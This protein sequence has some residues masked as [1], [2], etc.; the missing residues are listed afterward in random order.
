MRVL[1]ASRR[2][3][4]SSLLAIALLSGLLVAGIASPWAG[5]TAGANGSVHFSAPGLGGAAL[6][7][8]GAIV[9]GN[10][11]APD[12]G[13]FGGFA[14][15]GPAPA[16]RSFPSFAFDPIDGYSLLFG[17][18]SGGQ[19]LGDTW[20][21]SR[22]NW[23]NLTSTLATGPSPRYGASLA[24]DAVDGYMVLFGGMTA[25]GTVGDTWA[26]Q[27]GRW[28]SLGSFSN[29]PSPRAFAACAG[30][31]RAGPF[32]L[33]G[34]ESAPG[35]ALGDTWQF[36]GAHWSRMGGTFA[37]SPRAQAAF[38]YDLRDQYFLLF[39][40]RLANGAVAAD[41]W[42]YAAGTWTNLTGSVPTAPSAR[43]GAAAAFDGGHG[44]VLL[45]G[46][47]RGGLLSDTWRF[48]LGRWTNQTSTLPLSPPAFPGGGAAYDGRF[49]TFWLVG[50]P[51]S[52]TT[53][54]ALWAFLT[55]L[56]AKSNLLAT[57]EPPGVPMAFLAVAH[58]GL[59]PYQYL[60]NFG[61]GSVPVAGA[62]TTHTYSASGVFSAVLTVTDSRGAVV[63]VATPITVAVPPL[64]VVLTAPPSVPVHSVLALTAAVSGGN[65][66]YTLAW[67][68]LPA[69][70]ASANTARLDCLPDRVGNSSVVV[71][72]TDRTG[73]GT[74]ASAPVRVV[75]DGSV[76]L[77][78]GFAPAF[79]L[80]SPG[81]VL[82]PPL[83]GALAVTAA[84]AAVSFV[85][86][87]RGRLIVVSRPRFE[88]VT[89]PEWA[90][91]PETF[92][93]PSAPP[94]PTPGGGPIE[95]AP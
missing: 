43:Y 74:S 9:P 51:S 11:L 56:S 66:P 83:L 79:G 81:W 5:R 80:A 45:F 78:T 8:S 29:A 12:F 35:V 21:L 22:G 36:S 1:S 68:G 65:P 93:R 77:G 23:T 48:S 67:S 41:T 28:F 59:A 27:H 40:G 75:S 64:S 25:S 69:G 2:P 46:G 95:R 20:V 26:F 16:A 91:T 60:W 47:M 17:G 87:R 82:L 44:S 34:G 33:F 30:D 18:R 24:Y 54:V 63:S 19:I 38:A 73:E 15:G 13:W 62:N 37:P 58:G 94:G 49:G 89:L 70:C 88:C 14:T 7:A 71:T 61:D 57:S 52:G 50:T 6:T 3:S 86:A 4:G 53:T 55:P 32:V 31:P 76:G 39:G 84:L 90:E 72:V 85:A 10:Y 92:D 42:K